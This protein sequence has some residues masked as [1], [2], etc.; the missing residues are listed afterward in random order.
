MLSDL[1]LMPTFL[2]FAPFGHVGLNADIMGDFAR[3]VDNR[4]DQQFIPENC[5]AFAVVF[6]RNF[7]ALTSYREPGGFVPQLPDRFPALATNAC[8]GQ[9][10]PR[11][12]SR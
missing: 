8:Y 1:Q 4:R 7:T 12:Y 9:A 2:G 6:Q 5:A 11:A 3:V 10:I